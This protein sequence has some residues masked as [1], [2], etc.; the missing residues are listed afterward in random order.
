MKWLPTVRSEPGAQELG[1]TKGAQLL[2]QTLNEEKEAD[3]KL[4]EIA[5][6]GV[7]A[8]ASTARGGAVVNLVAEGVAA[9][10]AGVID[11]NFA[12]FPIDRNIRMR[13]DALCGA[14]S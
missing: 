13:R 9:E 4:T 14:R 2:E 12:M 8:E 10:A 7:N 6:S 5:T 3:K 1:D 11:R